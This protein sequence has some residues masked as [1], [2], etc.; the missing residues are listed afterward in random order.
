MFNLAAAYSVWRQKRALAS[1]K[2]STMLTKAFF[3]NQIT[4]DLLASLCRLFEIISIRFVIGRNVGVSRILWIVCI[5]LNSRY[6]SSA[7][8]TTSAYNMAAMSVDAVTAIT[9]PTTSLY[10][11]TVTSVKVTVCQTWMVGL[12]VTLCFVL[13]ARTLAG[14]VFCIDWNL[15]PREDRID[16]YKTIASETIPAVV[17]IVCLLWLAKTRLYNRY[18]RGT[19]QRKQSLYVSESKANLEFVR[20]LTYVTVAYVACCAVSLLLTYVSVFR[21]RGQLRSARLY[22]YAALTASCTAI[23]NPIIYMITNKTFRR[24]LPFL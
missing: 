11:F 19:E 12:L 17:L 15:E 6:A 13:P 23:F 10:V 18:A 16:F 7:C 14:H 24:T 1:P 22:S 3:S 21:F 5:F 4:A 8:Q 20:M 2:H 9:K